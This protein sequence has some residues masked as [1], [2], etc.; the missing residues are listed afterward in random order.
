MANRLNHQHKSKE[1]YGWG[2]IVNEMMMSPYLKINRQTD[3]HR[4]ICR[5]MAWAER[6][7]EY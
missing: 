3:G 1:H 5:Q 4:I 6:G 2:I 7:E